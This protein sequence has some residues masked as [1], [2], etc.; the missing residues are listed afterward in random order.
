MRILEFRARGFR[1]LRDV[2]LA[3][4]GSLNVMY[5]P[6]GAGKSN[7]IDAIGTWLATTAAF[8]HVSDWSATLRMSAGLS[9]AD[10]RPD[11]APITLGGRIDLGA[12]RIIEL[13]ISVQPGGLTAFTKLENEDG[14]DLRPRREELHDLLTSRLPERLFADVGATRELR[15][16]PKV[17]DTFSMTP[18]PRQ[19]VKHLLNK[20]RLKEA[21]ARAIISPDTRVR[22]DYRKLVALLQGPPLHR[23]TIEPVEDSQSG[24]FELFEVDE[25]GNALPVDRAG[26]GVIQVY[27][28]LANVVLQGV[29]VVA[30][31][32]PEA[33]LHAPTT[34]MQLRHL[35]RRLVDDGYLEQLFVATH[36]NLFDLDQDGYW[37]VSLDEAGDTVVERVA[38]LTRIDQQHLYE[39]GPAKRA[40]QQMLRYKPPTEIVYRL[41]DGSPVTAEELLRWLQD[42]DPRVLEFLR[43]LAGA[44]VQMIGARARRKT[45]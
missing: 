2:E 12:G 6:N 28:I 30:I 25:E 38:D 40:F 4:L 33:H 13:E 42:D 17:S 20:G 5:G 8:A 36:S 29:D 37:D 22:A 21:L 7:I 3:P 1:S 14:F 24:H 31:E 27:S 9:P 44:A 26:L 45:A 43:D 10:F 23:L 34:G 16:E 32:E 19:F 18:T 39:P 15:P 41:G 35:L 11:G